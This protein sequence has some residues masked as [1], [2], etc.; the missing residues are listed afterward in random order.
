MFLLS[1][2][3]WRKDATSIGKE[4]GMK[5]LRVPVSVL[6]KTF[7]IRTGLWLIVAVGLILALIVQTEVDTKYFLITLAMLLFLMCISFINAKILNA[8]LFS[9]FFVLSM[10]MLNYSTNSFMIKTV[11][12][13]VATYLY[14]ERDGVDP[15]DFDQR[16]EQIR[17]A[18]EIS[19]HIVCFDLWIS[20]IVSLLL[21]PLVSR[22]LKWGRKLLGGDGTETG[23]GAETRT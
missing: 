22:V 21:V 4:I 3:S 2:A 14:P 7:T 12:A 20:S 1:R 13:R 16:D 8:L 11:E 15:R 9:G 10:V 17:H 5:T 18:R 6:M 19:V 23:T